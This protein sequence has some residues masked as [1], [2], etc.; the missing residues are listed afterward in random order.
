VTATA[1][2]LL[3]DRLGLTDDELCR[4][5]DADPLTVIAGELD[6]RPEL[7]ILL[8]LTEDAAARLGAEVLR[9]WMRANGPSGRPLDHLTARDFGAFETDLEGL[10]QRGFVIRGGG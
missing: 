4:A 1:A 3:R 8:A 5:L 7:A 10:A 6:H 9:R 2:A